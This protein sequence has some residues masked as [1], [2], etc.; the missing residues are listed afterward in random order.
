MET[1]VQERRRSR[2]PL[3]RALAIALGGL[4]L[5]GCASITKPFD[6]YLPLITQ[7]GVYKLDINQG[8]Y[9]SQDMVDRL[10]VGQTKAQVKATLGTPLI[11]S[12][13]RENRWDYVYEY[14]SAGRLRDHRQFTVYFKD[15]LLAR[16]EGDEMP[17]SAQDLNRIAATRSLPEDPYGQ[18]A[19][20]I[21]KIIDLFKKVVDPS[22]A[23]T[24]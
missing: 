1:Q 17:Q 3:S 11:T 21:G 16:W 8:N 14:T 19:G 15:D 9:L 13:F 6:D 4:V 20:I 12:A 10:K 18:D 24:P 5:A 2:R 7:F 22:T 23:A